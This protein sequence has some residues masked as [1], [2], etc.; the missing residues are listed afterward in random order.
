MFSGGGE[1]ERTSQGKHLNNDLISPVIFVSAKKHFV[2]IR[3][4]RRCSEN[5]TF[6]FFFFSLFTA[7]LL[8]SVFQN[9]CWSF[10]CSLGPRSSHIKMSA[11]LFFPFTCLISPVRFD[12]ANSK[13]ALAGAIP[14]S[15][16]S[17]FLT[18]LIC[19]FI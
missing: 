13:S 1:W 4:E 9:C 8:L 18:C 2:V 14:E 15:Y 6:L 3:L 17:A 12:P 16:T 19:C 7:K 11:A 10:S 5:K